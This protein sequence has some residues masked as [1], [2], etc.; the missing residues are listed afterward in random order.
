[1][2]SGK[3]KNMQNLYHTMIMFAG[4]KASALRQS[5]AE[6]LNSD[7]LGTI[8]AATWHGLQIDDLAICLYTMLDVGEEHS[9]LISR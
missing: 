3:G 2:T 6:D 4:D 7:L 8:V 1:M 5:F 9:S